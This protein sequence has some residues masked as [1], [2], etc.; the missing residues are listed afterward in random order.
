MELHTFTYSKAHGWSI[1]NFPLIDSPKTLLII[2]GAPEYCNDQTPVQQLIAAYPNAKLIGCSTAGE[3]SGDSITD[4]SISVAVVKFDDT[5]LKSTFVEILTMD[6]SFKAGERIAH[7]LNAN[8]LRGVFILSDGLNVN[9]SQLV[10]GIN[11]VLPN[12]HGLFTIV[13]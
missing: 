6:D 7:E 11:S 9:G 10:R 3:I 2:F 1:K 4:H 5:V 13:K 8:N 12:K